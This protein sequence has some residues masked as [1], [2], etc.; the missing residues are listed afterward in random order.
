MEPVV[1]TKVDELDEHRETIHQ[2]IHE[3]IGGVPAFATVV[4]VAPGESGETRDARRIPP[5]EDAFVP[6]SAA[7]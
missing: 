1:E 3:S 5:R 7:Q 4:D 6:L 2:T